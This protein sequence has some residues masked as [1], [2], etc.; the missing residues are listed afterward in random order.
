MSKPTI[1][2][3]NIEVVAAGLANSKKTKLIEGMAILTRS[4]EQGGWESRG[5]VKV[6]AAIH[7]QLLKVPD[8]VHSQFEYN[9]KEKEDAFSAYMIANYGAD[10]Y[11]DTDLFVNYI[12]PFCNSKKGQTESFLRAFRALQAEVAAAWEYLDNQHPIPVIT[13]IGLSPRVTATLKEMN[14]EIDIS[15]VKPPRTENVLE[16]AIRWSDFS[17]KTKPMVRK[18][19]KKLMKWVTYIRWTKGIVHHTSR[20]SNIDYSGVSRACCEACGKGIPSG[21]LVPIEAKDTKNN[22]L[23]SMWL[24][25]DCARNIFGIKAQGVDKADLAK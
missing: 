6:M 1:T 22:R 17:K 8:S 14:L 10:C 25:E 13:A 18:N 24:G 12:L 15:S 11:L 21:R 2:Q 4:L 23:V 9:T 20:F 3:A 5:S 7:Q 16:Q 19:G